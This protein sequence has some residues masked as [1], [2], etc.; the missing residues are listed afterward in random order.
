QVNIWREIVQDGSG[1]ADTD[2]LAGTRRL[3]ERW[4]AIPPGQRAEMSIHAQRSFA[5]RFEIH[6]AVDSFLAVLENERRKDEDDDLLYLDE[7][8]PS[9]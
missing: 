8:R 4:Q 7:P 6:R 9:R 3:L 5:N 1:L 2:D